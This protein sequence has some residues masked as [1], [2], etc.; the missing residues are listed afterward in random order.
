[1]YGVFI[2]FRVFV[3]FYFLCVVVPLWHHCKTESSGKSRHFS[4]FGWNHK[5]G[6]LMITNIS[7]CLDQKDVADTYYHHRCF[8]SK[9]NV[10]GLIQT[11]Q[12]WDMTCPGLLILTIIWRLQKRDFCGVTVVRLPF[13]LS[14]IVLIHFS[15]RVYTV[16]YL[17]RKQSGRE[18]KEKIFDSSASKF[19]KSH[20]DPIWYT[21]HQMRGDLGW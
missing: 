10:R 9:S 16:E 2:S 17:D 3:F 5:T 18:K 13:P 6:G 7:F 19:A 4:I 21:K 12:L 20:S 1:M 14:M 11:C 15:S 8:A